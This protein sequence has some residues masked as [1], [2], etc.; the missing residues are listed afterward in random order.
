MFGCVPLPFQTMS[1]V[2]ILFLHECSGTVLYITYVMMFMRCTP[3]YGMSR[4]ADPD[5]RIILGSRIQ[6]CM[7]VKSWLQVRNE[8]KIQKG[9]LSNY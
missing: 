4:V 7:R 9:L 2:N 8:V 5:P 1:P 3:R 6:I